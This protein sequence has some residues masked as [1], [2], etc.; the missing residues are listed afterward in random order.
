MEFV[1]GRF[2]TLATLSKLSIFKLKI[3]WRTELQDFG[4]SSLEI[5]AKQAHSWLIKEHDDYTA[6]RGLNGTGLHIVPDS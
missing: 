1:L 6:Y 2:S 4:G 5:S 3:L